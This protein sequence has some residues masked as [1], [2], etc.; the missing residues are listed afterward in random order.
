MTAKH[1]QIELDKLLSELRSLGIAPDEVASYAGP[2]K[3][4]R[5]V[6]L[7]RELAT[8]ISAAINSAI[9]ALDEPEEPPVPLLAPND[10]SA[11]QKEILSWVALGKSN[12]VVASILGISPH[13]VDTHLRRAFERLGTTD[14]TVAAIK[15]INAGL[16]STGALKA[17]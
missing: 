3:S 10:L 8:R 2:Q 7:D 1:L 12:S 9:T 14:R 4:I 16:I 17:A 15:G 5:P 13:T 6:K 11:R